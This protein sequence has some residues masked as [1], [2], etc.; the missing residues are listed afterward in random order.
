MKSKVHTI[1]PKIG[2]HNPSELGFAVRVSWTT[3]AK[4][5]DGDLSQTRG[6]TLRKLA[7]ALNCSIE[8]LYVYKEN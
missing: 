8:D 7:K 3:A 6:E 5:W 1:A 2:I 4:L